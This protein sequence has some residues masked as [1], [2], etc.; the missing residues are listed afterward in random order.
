[1]PAKG[2]TEGLLTIQDG[3]SP[4]KNISSTILAEIIAHEF[5]H[6]LGFGHS[7]SNVALMYAS[8]TGLG[9]CCATTIVSPRAGSIERRRQQSDAAGRA[10]ESHRGRRRQPRRSLVDRTTRTT[11]LRRRSR[12]GERRLRERR[13]QLSANAT[14]VALNGPASGLYRVYVIASNAAGSSPQSNTVSFNVVLRRSR[15]SR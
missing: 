8:V 9:P 11:R 15:C 3:V 14:A 1:M 10:I 6:T 13:R 4:S 12:A 5:G 7:A 2:I